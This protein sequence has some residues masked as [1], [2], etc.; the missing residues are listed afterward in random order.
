MAGAITLIYPACQPVVVSDAVV[1]RPV[2]CVIAPTTVGLLTGWLT[3]QHGGRDKVAGVG[4][5][6]AVGV[7]HAQCAQRVAQGSAVGS[8]MEEEVQAVNAS[9]TF[10]SVS[11]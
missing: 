8:V 2:V 10:E 11:Q 5:D 6:L 7:L 1:W 3:G 9:G 4:H